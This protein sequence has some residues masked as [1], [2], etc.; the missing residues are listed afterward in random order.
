MS[1]LYNI[2]VNFNRSGYVFNGLLETRKAVEAVCGLLLGLLVCKFLPLKGLVMK[3]VAHT[4]FMGAFGL[5][6]LFGV[7][8]D[9]FSVFFL[10]FLRWRKLRK[11]PYIYNP[12]GMTFA[13]A[14]AKMVFAEQDAGDLIA[15]LLDGLHSKFSKPKPVYT[16]GETFKFADDPVLERLRMLE[17][18][19]NE[20]LAQQAAEQAE[21]EESAPSPGTVDLDVLL[22]GIG[23][24]DAKE[25]DENK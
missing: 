23:R 21:M 24:L 10:N 1:K 15:D 9:P 17:E 8:G 14:P 13:E 4:F 6:G 19:Q 5:L 16:E 7:R 11:K 3:I 2:P 12:H 25:G 20:L 22:E 18:Q